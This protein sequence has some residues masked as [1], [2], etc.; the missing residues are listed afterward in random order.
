MAASATEQKPPL[1]LASLRLS[2]R[3]SGDRRPLLQLLAPAALA[4]GGTLT[5]PSSG[6]HAIVGYNSLGERRGRATD[7]EVSDVGHGNHQS[8]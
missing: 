3:Q 5:G 1:G 2:V 8:N 6:G 4:E 7:H